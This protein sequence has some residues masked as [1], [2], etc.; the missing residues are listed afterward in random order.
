MTLAGLAQSFCWIPWMPECIEQIT[1]AHPDSEE[2][3]LVSDMASGLFAAGMSLGG[4]IGP[5]LGGFI[6]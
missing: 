3:G 6:N 1:I 4:V 5:T 2:A